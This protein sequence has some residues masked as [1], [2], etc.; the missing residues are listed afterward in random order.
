MTNHEIDQ[1]LD[2]GAAG[3]E[4]PALNTDRVKA[5]IVGDLRPVKPLRSR[6]VFLAG[7]SAIFIVLCGI[8][9]YRLGPWGWEALSLPRK[10]L[11]FGALAASAALLGSS[12]V[13]RM[14]PGGRQWA[15]PA[16]APTA[17]FALLALAIAGV[18]PFEKDDDF[19]SAGI[20]CMEAGARYAIVAGICFWLLLRRAAWLSPRW[21]GVA[22]GTLAGLVGV[23]VLEMHCPLLDAYHILAWHLGTAALGAASGFLLGMLGEYAQRKS[24]R[25]FWRTRAN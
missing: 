4:K 19:L 24:T 11:M 23:T 8:G 16:L 22:T 21:E 10:M 5:A 7:F 3:M 15:G 14:A 18:F 2:A 25:N 6:W 12:L 13:R 1:Y 17:V 20:I 9:A